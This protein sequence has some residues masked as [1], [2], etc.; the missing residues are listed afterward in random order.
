MEVKEG[1]IL[2]ELL[3]ANVFS[4]FSKQQSLVFQGAVTPKL[5]RF[6]MA[7]D[8]GG[9]MI[10]LASII[11]RDEKMMWDSFEELLG[12]GVK[13]AAT[14]LQGIYGFDVLSADI[15]EG[16]RH[17]NAQDFADLLVNHGRQLGFGQ[18]KLIRY[19]QIFSILHKSL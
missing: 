16:S 4:A 5:L 6:L 13:L 7:N 3:K 17:F 8:E 1:P 11:S 14:K 18:Q 15:Q 19:G 10:Y 12:H 2:I 9:K